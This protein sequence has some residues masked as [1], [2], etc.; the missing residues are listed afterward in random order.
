MEKENFKS[1]FVSIIGKPN[2]GKS[3]LMNAM[4]GENLSAI[5]SKAQTTRHRIMGVI[6]TDEFQM[7]Y[8]DTPGILEPEYELHKS[9]MSFVH[10]SLE[11]ADVILFVVDLMDKYD[12]ESIIDTLNDIDSKVILVINKSDLNKGSRMTDK[13]DYWSLILPD[14]EIVTVSA[15]NGDNIEELMNKIKVHLPVHPPYYPKDTLTDKPEK[16]FAS[17]IIREK[18]FE[19]YKQEI[20]YST[21]VEIEAFKEEADIVRIRAEIFVERKTQKG[22]IIG[23]KG[24]A[25]K[26]VGTEARKDLEIFFGKKVFLETFVKVAENW[27]KNERQLKRFGYKS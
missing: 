2:V 6:T 22:I 1:G 3:T 18:I 11:D 25:L 16:F 15:L 9:M 19:N 26:K 21:E 14:K 23:K 10:A 24:E 4:V 17:E 13:M 12:D 20:P 8:S 7:V 27:R 5:T